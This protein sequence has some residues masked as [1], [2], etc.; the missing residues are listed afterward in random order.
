MRARLDATQWHLCRRTGA[1]RQPGMRIFAVLVG[2]DWHDH[3]QR[4]SRSPS[5][6]A[7]RSD[8]AFPAADLDS[9]EERWRLGGSHPKTSSPTNE[10]TVAAMPIAYRPQATAIPMPA[11]TQTPAA[12]VRPCTECRCTMIAPAPIKPMPL[13]I[14]AATREGDRKSVV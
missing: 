10:S 5:A 14:C 4:T 1:E 6:T 12:V 13:T 3:E 7:Y 2:N 8:A 9:P 11:A